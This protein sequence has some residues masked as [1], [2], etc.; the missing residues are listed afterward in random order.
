MGRDA[1]GHGLANRRALSATSSRLNLTLSG[2]Q[3]APKP[4]EPP[5]APAPPGVCGS[6]RAV[7]PSG[8]RATEAGGPVPAWHPAERRLAMGLGIVGLI[9]AIVVAVIIL[10]FAGIL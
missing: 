8:A 4:P 6:P 5:K 10:R 9:G 2:V 3:P 7:G 1:V